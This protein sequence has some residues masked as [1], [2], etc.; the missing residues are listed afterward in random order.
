MG[1]MIWRQNMDFDGGQGPHGRYVYTEIVAAF[2]ALFSLIWL[3]PFTWSMM[4]YPL[5]LLTSIAWFASFA[6]LI[7]WISQDDVTCSG[8]FGLWFW[9][10][11]THDYYCSEYLTIEGL[12]FISGVLWL[13][14]AFLVS[15]SHEDDCAGVNNLQSIHVFHRV[16]G[17]VS[18][19]GGPIA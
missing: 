13:L 19:H 15:P 17:R 2:S 18:K 1:H 9:D 16:R 6:A 3:I 4:H 5:D 10:G 8:V 12:A 11:F 14:S 7:Q